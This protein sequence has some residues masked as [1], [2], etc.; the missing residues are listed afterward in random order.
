MKAIRSMGVLALLALGFLATRPSPAVGQS[1]KLGAVVPLT[2]RYGSGG[3]QVRAGYEIA[4][5]HLNA[6][7]HR[8]G[9]IQPPVGAPCDVRRIVELAGLRAP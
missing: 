5:E 1:I 2:G 8:V 7:I 6:K 3:A 4:V 9:D